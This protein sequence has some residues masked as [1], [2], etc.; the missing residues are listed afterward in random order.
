MMK[1]IKLI[2]EQLSGNETKL[3]IILMHNSN[4][5]SYLHEAAQE[6]GSWFQITKP[7]RA[8]ELYTCLKY[9]AAAEAEVYPESKASW[10]KTHPIQISGKAQDFDRR[11]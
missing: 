3:P 11:G 9:L 10:V 4:G 6:L 2:R 5:D 8:S 1:T 7:V